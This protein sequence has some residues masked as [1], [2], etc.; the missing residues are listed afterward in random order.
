M[1]NGIFREAVLVPSLS[2]PVAFV[3]SGLLLMLFILIVAAVSAPWLQLRSTS[4]SLSVGLLWLC[5]TLLFE[6]AFGGL[7]RGRS[8][9]E[10]LEAYTFKDGNIW[11]VVL[12][13]PLLAPFAAFR[14]RARPP[15]LSSDET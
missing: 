10:M 1:V 14:L 2:K 12:V 11:P 15:H 3:V 7:V 13:V 9:P 8:L 4:S 5:L 6:F